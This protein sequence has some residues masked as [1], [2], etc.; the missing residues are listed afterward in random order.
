[1]WLSECVY[2]FNSYQ[3]CFNWLGFLSLLTNLNISYFFTV[4]IFCIYIFFTMQFGTEFKWNVVIISDL[5]LNLND[6][7]NNVHSRISIVENVSLFGLLFLII[8]IGPWIG[9]RP[10]FMTGACSFNF[11]VISGLLL[12][13]QLSDFGPKTHPVAQT[14][15]K[16]LANIYKS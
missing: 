11:Y 2:I 1:M 3:M 10:N 5:V 12:T 6:L 9:S 14:R 8:V 16:V 13:L 7:I 15:Q 4:L